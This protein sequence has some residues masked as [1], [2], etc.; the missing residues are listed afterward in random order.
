MVNFYVTCNLP[1]LLKSKTKRIMKGGGVGGE[2]EEVER[3]RRARTP[4]RENCGG[5]KGIVLDKWNKP[6]PQSTER[7]GRAER[8]REV[9]WRR[10][11]GQEGL[12]CSTRAGFRKQVGSIHLFICSTR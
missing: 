10:G 6:S 4:G 8:G 12:P 3:R 7:V 11:R 1:Q 9:W 5:P 2:G